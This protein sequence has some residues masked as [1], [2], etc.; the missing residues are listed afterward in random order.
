MHEVVDNGDFIRHALITQL[1]S[2]SNLTLP[3]K[4]MF[5]T[6]LFMTLKIATK[7]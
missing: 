1:G 5:L 3:I 7:I 2:Q 4:K 6:C